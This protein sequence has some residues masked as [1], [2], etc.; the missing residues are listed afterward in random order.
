MCYC[1]LPSRNT[2]AHTPHTC[3]YATHITHLQLCHHPPPTSLPPPSHH[4]CAGLVQL[5]PC[6]T[7]AAGAT[8]EP[9]GRAN[10]TTHAHNSSSSS[11]G[12]RANNTTHSNTSYFSATPW[13][14]KC[15]LLCGRGRQPATEAS[16]S[17]CAACAAAAAHTCM[18]A[19][20]SPC[21]QR[22]IAASG[23]MLQP[24]WGAKG[25]ACCSACDSACCCPTV[26]VGAGV[27]RRTRSNSCSSWCRLQR[28]GLWAGRQQQPQ[29]H[30]CVILCH[31]GREQHRRVT[32]VGHTCCAAT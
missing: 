18:S 2:Q 24:R 29:Q 13:A 14:Q 20:A 15:W 10:N 16:L 22:I 19:V 4:R 21:R 26:A 30:T 32:G 9:G 23:T 31:R 5:D 7:R 27:R 25:C 12:G 28:C 1:Q 11:T 3:S 6:G 17:R 8:T